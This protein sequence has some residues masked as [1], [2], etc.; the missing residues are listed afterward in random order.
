MFY[1]FPNVIVADTLEKNGHES[2]HDQK[3]DAPVSGAT[4]AANSFGAMLRDQSAKV[5]STF[6]RGS[7]TE[8][9]AWPQ[10][11]FP[12]YKPAAINKDPGLQNPGSPSFLNFGS[13]AQTSSKGGLFGSKPTALN[14]NSSSSASVFSNTPT[15][16]FGGFSPTSDGPFGQRPQA[17]SSGFGSGNNASRIF[18]GS[19]TKPGAGGPQV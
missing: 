19:I 5:A 9:N 18:G 2:R 11:K 10:S 17:N 6:G 4:A 15:T 12:G 7:T 16:P 13:T 8:S 3:V 1:F 14:S